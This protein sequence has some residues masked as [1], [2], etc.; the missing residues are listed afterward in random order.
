MRSIVRA[1]GCYL[2]F[3]LGG[4]LVLGT[5]AAYGDRPVESAGDVQDLLFL[6]SGSPLLVRLHV[7]INSMPLS[8]AYREGV[9]K[10]HA[11]LDANG[12]GT[13]T[14]EEAERVEWP[15]LRRLLNGDPPPPPT[16]MT[17]GAP[18]PA[19]LP[20][21]DSGPQDGV[22]SVDELAELL[23]AV[24]RPLTVQ[25]RPA[26]ESDQDTTFA[27][28][29]GNGDGT[30]S[31]EERTQAAA[32]LRK[33]D[34]NDD[35]SL[36]VGE[37]A[38]FRNPIFGL[39][40]QQQRGVSEPPV[41]V[42]DPGASRIRM[43]QQL[44]NRLD[45]GGAEGSKTK[46]HRL[47]R[48]E[49][50][51][52]AETFKQF[53]NDGDE[54]LDSDE[55]MQFLDLGEPAVEMIVRLGPRPLKQYVIEFI[56]RQLTG[57]GKP[58][59]GADRVP[60][61]LDVVDRAGQ[62]VKD[63]PR[64]RMKRRNDTLVTLDL[65]DVLVD[66][67]TEQRPDD[68]VRARAILGSLFQNLDA[69]KDNSLS[70]AEVQNREPLAS[71]FRLMDRNG[72]GQLTKGEMTA[73]VTLLEELSH[74]QALLGVADR[75]VLLFGNLDTNSDGRVGL[76]ELRTASD[77]LATFDRNGDGQL[78]AAEIP[79]RFEWF[80]S[81]A[82]LPLGSAGFVVA[83]NVKRGMAEPPTRAASGGPVWFQKM[84]R[85]HDG[86]LSPREFLGSLAEFRRLDADGDG[87]IGALEAK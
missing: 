45:T 58:G 63:P 83:A 64:V 31:A 86:D 66:I 75:G 53:D 65:G 35:E 12:D 25:T 29:D 48:A 7:Q 20:A 49:I 84:D 68:G 2:G 56:D 39:G 40:M 60:H 87:L 85:N 16:A 46:D 43:V 36:S 62:G 14:R 9:G 47:S 77:R 17:K 67:L 11:Y 41:V 79:H 24:R 71:L 57:Q 78:A 28:I 34:Q 50:G 37:L 61:D 21:L 18:A 59:L 1:A 38:A 3:A 33:F 69:D 22:V 15:R 70:L 26:S 32:V 74:R 55:L 76:R 52:G 44:L 72:D 8:A 13:L 27:R 80:I 82:P 51:L 23:L 30:L 19:E 5:T 73:A 6:G 10:L 4:L 81:Q 54:M 42:L